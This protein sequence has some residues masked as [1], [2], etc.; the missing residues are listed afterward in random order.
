[1]NECCICYEDRSKVVFSCNHII[2]LFC[3]LKLNNTSCPYCRKDLKLEI[4]DQ[5]LKIINKDTEQVLSISEYY[6]NW[7]NVNINNIPQDYYDEY[8]WPS[9][10]DINLNP[11]NTTVWTYDE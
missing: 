7:N 2:C 4:P 5:I 6:N 1:M 3:L 11:I 8:I 10:Y 9:E